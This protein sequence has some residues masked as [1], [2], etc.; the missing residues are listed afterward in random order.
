MKT[1][2]DIMNATGLSRSFILT[3][4]KRNNVKPI[5]IGDKN[6]K[7]WDDGA[8]EL[9]IHDTPRTEDLWTAT[10]ISNTL[11]VPV[12]RIKQELSYF[13]PILIKPS[14]TYYNEM[15]YK[16]IKNKLTPQLLKLKKERPEDHP[17]VTD[18]RWLDPD[19]WPDTKLRGY[20]ED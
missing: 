11:G 20:D 7:V 2:L 3:V 18:H 19:Q 14:G 17:L 16:C 12:D 10:K 4:L 1:T 5:G 6:G 15:T 9:V 13:D 8:L